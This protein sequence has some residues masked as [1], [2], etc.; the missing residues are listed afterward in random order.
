MYLLYFRYML[1]F[2]F[3][4]NSNSMYLLNCVA[5]YVLLNLLML[6]MQEI[7]FVMIDSMI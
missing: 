2:Y 4:S 6:K 3:Y 1:N 7:V 5:I